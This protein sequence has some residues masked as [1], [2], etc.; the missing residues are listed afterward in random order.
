MHSISTRVSLDEIQVDMLGRNDV[1]SVQLILFT[2][3]DRTAT[4]TTITGG[5]VNCGHGYKWSGLVMVPVN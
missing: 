4:I 3:F 5:V 2:E 1:F